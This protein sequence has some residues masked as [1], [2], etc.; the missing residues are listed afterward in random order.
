MRAATAT[1]CST[2]SPRS[3]LLRADLPEDQRDEDGVSCSPPRALYLPGASARGAPAFRRPRPPWRAGTAGAAASGA[4]WLRHGCSSPVM[5]CISRRRTSRRAWGESRKCRPKRNRS[6]SVAGGGLYVS[7]RRSGWATWSM[8]STWSAMAPASSMSWVTNISVVARGPPAC[9]GSGCRCGPASRRPALGTAARTATGWPRQAG[10]GAS[11]TCVRRPPDSLWISCRAPGRDRCRRAG[12]LRAAARWLVPSWARISV[13]IAMF[14]GV[15]FDGSS[16]SD[17]KQ[18]AYDWR[19]AS[20]QLLVEP[21]TVPSVAPGS[22]HTTRSS[23][24]FLHP[25]GPRMA[26]DFLVVTRTDMLQ[27]ADVLERVSRVRAGE[28]GPRPCRRRSRPQRPLFRPRAP[29][30]PR[31]GGL[32]SMPGSSARPTL[33]GSST[34]SAS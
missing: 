24:L 25:L 3:T 16:A 32:A 21:D 13:P 27:Q 15:V 20:H 6:S 11:A 22:P 34:I 28:L 17:W 8:T 19:Y 12:S 30:R 18:E 5:P 31:R 1:G 10:V 29:R 23:A 7:R 2:T 33:G 9:G 14:S 26:M 4:I